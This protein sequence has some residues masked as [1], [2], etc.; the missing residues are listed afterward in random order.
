MAIQDSNILQGVPLPLDGI[1]LHPVNSPVPPVPTNPDT[2]NTF[3]QPTPFSF[4]KFLLTRM[5]PLV[6]ILASLALVTYIADP[7]GIFNGNND[8]ETSSNSKPLFPD[9]EKLIGLSG[10]TSVEGS[11]MVKGD[12]TVPNV[13][14]GI[15]GGDN[16]TITGDAQRPTISAAFNEADSLQS[17][18]N[19]GNNTSIRLTL[20]GGATLGDVL[21]LA[22]L[23]TDPTSASNGSLYYNTTSNVFRCYTN[24][25]WRNCDTDTVSEGDGDGDI[26]TVTAGD[27]LTGGGDEGDVTLEI[28]LTSSSASTSTTS[29]SG[30]EISSSGLSLLKGCTNGQILKWNSTDWACANDAA[31]SGNSIVQEGGV[32]VSSSIDTYNFNGSDFNVSAAGSTATINLDYTNSHI[33]RDNQTQAIS[34]AWSF[35]DMTISDTNIALTGASTTLTS[36]GAFI[37]A[38]GGAITLGNGGDTFAINSSDWDISTSGT[39]TNASY[40]GLTISPTSG[41]LTIDNGK[42][43]GISNT[44]AFTGTDG[45]SFAFPGSSGTVCTTTTCLSSGSTLFNTAADS[46]T[47]SIISGDTLTINGTAAQGISTSLSGD[48]FTLTVASA[49]ADGA[50]K[51]VA[52]FNATNFSAASGV[53]NTIQNINSTASPTFLGLIVSGLSINSAVYTD[54]SSGLTTTAPTSGTIGYWSRSGTTLS[55]ATT[56]DVVSVTSNVTASP[57]INLSTSGVFTGTGT[58]S[59]MPVYANS[60]TTGDLLSISATALTTGTALNIVGPSGG[61]AGMTDALVKFSGNVGETSTLN[62]LISSTASFRGGPSSSGVNLYLSS[63]MNQSSAAFGYGMYNRL[64]DATNLANPVSAYFADVSST[65]NVGKGLYGY[66]ASVSTTSTVADTLISHIGIPYIN[67]GAVITIGTRTAVS[68]YAAPGSLGNSTGGTTNVRGFQ[69]LTNGTLAVGAGGTLNV[70][71]FY[72]GNPTMNTIGTTTKFGIQLEDYSVSPADANYAVCFDCDGTYSNSSAINGLTWGNDANSVTLY[73]SASDTLATD[74][75]LDVALHQAIGGAASVN[76]N[77]GAATTNTLLNIREQVTDETKGALY[78]IVNAVNFAPSGAT[79]TNAYGNY[80]E[81]SSSAGNAQNMPYLSSNASYAYHN[82]TGTVAAAVGTET[83]ANNTGI[84]TITGAYGLNVAIGNSSTGVI[85]TAYGIRVA[86]A[87]NSGGGSYGTNYGIHVMPQTVGSVDYGVRID[88]ADT[89]TLWI[90]GD[91]NNTTAT[92]G[93]AFGSSRDTNLYRSAANVLR[94]DDSFVIEGTTGLTFAGAGADIIFTNGETIDNDTN[95]QITLGLGASGTLL[96]TSTTTA[97]LT[98]SAGA[99]AINAF[100]TGLNLQADGAVDVNIAGGSGATGCTVT[101]SSGNLTCT[102]NITGANAGTAGYWSRSGTTLSPATAADNVSVGNAGNFLAGQTTGKIGFGGAVSGSDYLMDITLDSTQDWSRGINITQSNNSNE[103]SSVFN[104]VNL[105]APGSLG[106]GT[107]TIRN[108]FLNFTPTASLNDGS[109][110]IQSGSDFAIGLGSITLGDSTSTN[111]SATTYGYKTAISGTPTFNDATV[112]G[113]SDLLIYGV[114]SSV[115]IT[116]TLTNVYQGYISSYAGIFE[117]SSTSA[118]NANLLNYQYA[119]YASSTGNLTTTGITRH[120]GGY[121]QAD[122]TADDN[123]GIYV[124]GVGQATNNYGLFLTGVNSASSSYAIFSSATA[125]SYF[126]G[127]VG[128]GDSSP[129]SLL[130]VGNGDLFTV[131]TIGQITSTGDSLLDYGA[132][133]A[134]ATDRSN[135]IVQDGNFI[136][137][138]LFQGY[139]GAQMWDGAQIEANVDGTPGTNDMPGRIRFLTTPDG[140]VSPVERMRIASTGYVGIGT[141]T[142]TPGYRLDVQENRASGYSASFTNTGNNADRLGLFVAAGGASGTLIQFNSGGL[143]DVGEITFSGSTATYGTTSDKRAKDNIVDTHYGLSDLLKVQTRDYVFNTDQTGALKTGFIAQ[144]LYQIYPDAVYVPDDQNKLWSI[145]Y[146]KMTPLIVAGI[147]EL[148]QKVD[149]ELLSIGTDGN[150]VVAIHAETLVLDENADISGTVTASDY[151][152]DAA[153]FTRTG[154]LAFLPI[155]DGKSSV[156]DALNELANA[157]NET[158]EKV[159]GLETELTEAQELGQQAI[160]HALSLDEKVAS[161]S[162]SIDS[163]TVQIDELLAGF[164][165]EQDEEEISE[166]LINPE[167]MIASDSAELQTILVHSE[168][169]ISGTL[170]AYDGIFQNSLKSLGE[171]MLANTTIAGDLTVDGSLSMTGTS[172]NTIGTLLIQ[173]SSLAEKVDFFNGLFTIDKGGKVF[174]KVIVA[175]QFKVKKDVSSGIATIPAGSTDLAILNNLVKNDSIISLTAETTTSVPVAVKEKVEDSGFVVSI[176]SAQSDDIKFNYLIVGQE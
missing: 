70:A 34:G 52:A 4:K 84:G 3:E 27:G 120:Y 1:A 17:V 171:T 134:L 105:A 96:L 45:T 129:S 68:F 110:L 78:G 151:S 91:A 176:I 73:R 148:N 122:G 125:Q 62:G 60:A 77:L 99:L 123:Y 53:I 15:V 175:D 51:G 6:I 116:P 143:T 107:R 5:L 76:Q 35:A 66:W 128:I 50:T 21:G 97:T 24:G 174:A 41:T 118:G 40:E 108:S 127:S 166:G 16:I 33:T 124:S 113:R 162:S 26:N 82:G 71:G 164:G 48:T 163:L 117:N 115:S 93:I 8:T 173:S 55:P 149:N 23:N 130:T 103:D 59:L 142:S 67:A 167:M 38:P 37:L 90:S 137:R 140:S 29:N 133:L 89:Q 63:T 75:N 56:N 170:Q 72:G 42:T 109:V 135:A 158:S 69:Y 98:N 112:S 74:D 31:G 10:N 28:L 54:G 157:Q 172:I 153:K 7:L 44:L 30:L 136:G 43:L 19:R 92:A 13:I 152:L 14:Y 20:V 81:L 57:L 94:T 168:A 83:Y 145:D 58:N 46:G 154:V 141:A 126:A 132:Q 11:L 100:A 25:A 95:N 150:A 119:I 114:S 65:G 147:Q 121:F 165:T 36:T 144:D 80:T 79:S 146:G 131:D 159:L 88:A 169:T 39:I 86:S 49:A 138:I 160:E 104:T 87:S 64:T 18:T 85:T 61:T 101:N 32:T 47:S 22:T 155:L 161:T 156:V 9:V 111:L 106:S 12:I 2:D 102:G 139:D